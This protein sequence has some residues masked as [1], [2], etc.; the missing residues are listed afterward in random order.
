MVLMFRVLDFSSLWEMAY[1]PETIFMPT[2]RPCCAAR[3]T[4]LPTAR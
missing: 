1:S 4:A 3:L 2:V